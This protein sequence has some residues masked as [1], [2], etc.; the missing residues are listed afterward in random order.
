[1]ESYIIRVYRFE[2]H[3]S[4]AGTVQHVE[5]A[6]KLTFSN[7]DELWKILQLKQAEKPGVY[8][9]ISG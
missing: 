2:Q 3:D 5:Q 8:T 6:D 9:A 1:M 4:I 7:I